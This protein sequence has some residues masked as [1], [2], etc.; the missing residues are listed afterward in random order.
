MKTLEEFTKQNTMMDM[1][2]EL[3]NETLEE[4]LGGSEDEAEEDA[5]VNQGLCDLV[6]LLF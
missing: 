6:K 3:I 5:V 4:A 2:D 1:K